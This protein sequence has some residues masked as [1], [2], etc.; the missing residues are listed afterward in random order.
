MNLTEVQQSARQEPER[1]MRC[2]SYELT[3]AKII[4]IKMTEPLES[5]LSHLQFWNND[6]FITI[7]ECCQ[8]YLCNARNKPYSLVIK[9]INHADG[10]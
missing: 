9:I 5:I 2:E 7:G 1:Q 4:M 3:A 8:L 6:I 10:F